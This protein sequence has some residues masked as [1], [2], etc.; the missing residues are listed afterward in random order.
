MNLICSIKF[1][2]NLKQMKTLKLTLLICS[3]F[4]IQIALHS[5][6]DDEI[7]DIDPNA[8]EFIESGNT[9]TV[10]DHGEGVGDTTFTA[11]KTWILGNFVFVNAGQILTIEPGTVIK[12]VS[13][14]G[15]NASALIIAQGGKI[16]ASGTADKPIIF[17]ALADDLNGSISLTDRGL[18]GGV[19]ILGKARIN[20]IPSTINI[21]GIPTTE[22]RGAYGGTDDTDN[23]GVFRYVSIRHGGT[24]IGADNEINGLTMGGVGS[25]TTIDHIEV[26]ANNDDG[27]EFF[28]GTV[29]T[30]Y[31]I[32]AFNKDDAFDYDQGYRGKAQFW[33]A[34][35][36]QNSGDRLI[37]QDGADDPE[38]GT[39][40]GIT[41]I[42]NATFIGAN[43]DGGR[44]LTFRANSGG[45]WF[46]SIFVNQAKG[47]DVE[48]KENL[49]AETSYKRLMQG[50][51]K[52]ENNIF[53]NI[54]SNTNE[55]VFKLN[56]VDGVVSA[57]ST[58]AAGDLATYF[59]SANNTLDF[60]PGITAV[61]QGTLN[62]V[63][64]NDVTTNLAPYDD[65]FYTTV[66][67]KGAFD[68]NSENWA[69]NWTLLFK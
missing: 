41:T 42:Y 33:L 66:N 64:T 22:S 20:T 31:L 15:E 48:L 21:E 46:N 69:K 43:K 28:G 18:W 59:S 65:S 53:F 24:N 16:N 35:Q 26:Y 44:T 60:D 68:P 2:L 12:G 4:F 63:P 5:C 19:I 55:S 29:N 8:T 17:T 23:S 61:T 67:Y 34:V 13:G 11:D 54:A 30:K 38:D 62:P 40:F 27:F 6:K 58:Q 51:L 37:E 39:P 57:D 45:K 32:S 50:D 3:I 56:V 47:V 52:V 9:V 25:A 49:S 14:E 1:K 36:D 10:I 7:I